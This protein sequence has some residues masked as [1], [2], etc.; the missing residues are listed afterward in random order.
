M[1]Y[2]NTILEFKTPICFMSS[3]CIPTKILQLEGQWPDSPC[4][5]S[6]GEYVAWHQGTGPYHRVVFCEVRQ[7]DK[8]A[9]RRAIARNTNG[10][11]K[12]FILSNNS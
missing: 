2:E 9:G 5:V 12:Y 11:L 8:P 6:P 1:C 4:P 10:T 7:V 3:I